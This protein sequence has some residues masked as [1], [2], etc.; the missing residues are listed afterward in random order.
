M[1]YLIE[2]KDSNIKCK[3]N[4]IQ[5]LGC[6]GSI[7][8]AKIFFFFYLYLQGYFRSLETKMKGFENLI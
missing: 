4:R 1:L 5:E 2:K 6:S 8:T 3:L 7:R